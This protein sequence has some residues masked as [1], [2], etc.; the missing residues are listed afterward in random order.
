MLSIERN[1]LWSSLEEMGNIGKNEEKN[2]GGRTRLAFGAEDLEARRLLARWM[3]ELGL[4]VHTDAYANLWGLRRGTD[5]TARPVVVGSHID[6]VKNA[7]MFDGVMGVLSGLAVVRAMNEA[8]I[9]TRRPVAVVSFT[10]EEGGH[11]S[12]GGV[13]GCRLMA[14]LAD[15]GTIGEMKNHEGLRWKDALESSAFLGT[16]RLESH[17]YLEYHIEQGPV[18]DDE[19]FE[20][21]V[22]EGI[23]GV[24]WVR[25]TFEGE[26]NH[27]GAFP[28]NRRRDAGLC[29]A[30]VVVR[31]NRLAFELGQGTVVTPGQVTLS[32]NLPNIVPGSALMTVD[33][34]QFD[35]KLLEEGIARLRH[36]VEDAAKRHGVESTFEVLSRLPRAAFSSEMTSLVE[37]KARDL[38]LRYKRMPS[39]AGHDAQVMH[40]L[41]P[42][43][44]I[45]APSLGGRSHCPEEYT[46][47]EDVENGANV[48]LQCV[49]EL[50][51]A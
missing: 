2:G 12:A 33:I 16:S 10:D 14:G 24:S 36:I 39:G 45:F 25:V 4:E 32:P 11:F 1:K 38:G 49:L 20:I 44:M 9:A 15:I 34:R 50:A 46:R 3:K 40:T 23:V 28:M 35:P 18:L 43:A 22:V 48:L 41:C 17:A 7:G 27:A 37:R 29:A 30:D 5:P 51:Q 21:G 26:A 19:G 8:N 6:T 13:A 31:L 42:T 47:P